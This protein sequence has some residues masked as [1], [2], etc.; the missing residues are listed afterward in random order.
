MN[1][2]R[3]AFRG[4]Y[5]AELSE[6]AG[7]SRAEIDAITPDTE[8]LLRYDELIT[9]VKEASRVNL[10]Q[11]QLRQEIENLGDV[12]VKIAKRVPILQD[13]FAE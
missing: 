1:R 10:A 8:D 12:A 11:A 4:R 13:I 6:L 7:L 3:E 2:G 9:V 5:R